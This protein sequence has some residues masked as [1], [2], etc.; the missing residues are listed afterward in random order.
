MGSLLT[1]QAPALPLVCHANELAVLVLLPI[2][3]WRVV[4]GEER[5]PVGDGVCELPQA[6]RKTARQS[7]STIVVWR[8]AETCF[9]NQLL[10]ERW[11]PIGGNYF[12]TKQRLQGGYDAFSIF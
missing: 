3:I 5:E 4:L 9:H 7:G 12:R 10:R 2:S 1:L 6:A 11:S 8:G